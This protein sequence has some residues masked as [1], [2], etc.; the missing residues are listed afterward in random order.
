VPRKQQSRRTEAEPA[1][2]AEEKAEGHVRPITLPRGRGCVRT[3]TSAGARCCGGELEK[4]TTA[5]VNCFA[6]LCIRY[7]TISTPLGDYLR[8]M[9]TKLGPA[10]AITATARK[11][12]I[13]FYTMVKKQ[14]EHDETIWATQDLKRKQRLED[15]LKCQARQLGYQLVPLQ[16]EA[17]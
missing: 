5:L 10:G 7:T 4:P 17:A 11:I 9:K 3:T 6:T 12:A 13:I 15:R 1:Q 8:R 14:V 2:G 16:T